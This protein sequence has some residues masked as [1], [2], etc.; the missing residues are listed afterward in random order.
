MAIP[1]YVLFF[2]GLFNAA[3]SVYTIQHRMV[4]GLVNDEWER[5]WKEA[6][7]A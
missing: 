5:F 3:V 7:V 4:A 6:I 2:C 1:F